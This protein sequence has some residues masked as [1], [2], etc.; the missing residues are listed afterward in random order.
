MPIVSAKRLQPQFRGFD[1]DVLLDLS[2][3]FL[4]YY[5]YVT[6]ILTKFFCSTMAFMTV[7]WFTV[8]LDS[9]FVYHYWIR[10]SH[11]NYKFPRYS[12]F[13]G[14]YILET[15]PHCA[16]VKLFNIFKNGL[17]NNSILVHLHL[18]ITNHH[19]R[20]RNWNNYAKA[21][22]IKYISLLSVFKDA[23]YVRHLTTR[24]SLILNICLKINN[25]AK[26]W[27][28]MVDLDKSRRPEF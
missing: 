4:F 19:D 13:L 16:L 5:Y 8:I 21:V 12:T 10:L 26:V 23:P 20:L 14:R 28:I 27:F 2:T 3:L 22:G 25:D 1:R 18:D 9:H 24:L 6:L 11:W 7:L 17:D 15:C